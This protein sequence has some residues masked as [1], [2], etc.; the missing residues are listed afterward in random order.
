LRLQQ[1]KT[2]H[3]LFDKYGPVVRIGPNKV[4][5][6]DFTSMRSI[7]SVHK[8]DKSTFYKSLLTYV[9]LV[10]DTILAHKPI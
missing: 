3:R 8:F 1:C 5:F 9:Y 6:K 2:N 4:I 7:Y 10:F